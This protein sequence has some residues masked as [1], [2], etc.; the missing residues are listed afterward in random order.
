[1]TAHST[2]RRRMSGLGRA[3]ILHAGNLR[4]RAKLWRMEPLILPAK[5]FEQRKVHLV[6]LASAGAFAGDDV[7]QAGDAENPLAQAAGA[8]G[9]FVE[10]PGDFLGLQR[11]ELSALAQLTRCARAR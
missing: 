11:V 4:G 10:G 8:G 6:F 2:A 5:T 9:G 7:P 1:M 3:G